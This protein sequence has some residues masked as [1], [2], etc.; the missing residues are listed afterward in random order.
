MR[1]DI[2]GYRLKA[3][4]D[5]IATCQMM[6]YKIDALKLS[7]K[8]YL[9]KFTKLEA[10]E[11]LSSMPLDDPGRSRYVNIVGYDPNEKWAGP[12]GEHSIAFSEMMGRQGIKP[13]L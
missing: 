4:K 6:L 12:L 3:A 10:L 8:R 1:N 11:V 2:A 5:S 9:E 13:K 7:W